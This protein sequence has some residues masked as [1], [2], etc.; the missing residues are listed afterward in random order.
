[1][2][3]QFARKLRRLERTILLALQLISMRVSQRGEGV[4]TLEPHSDNN[5]SRVYDTMGTHGQ[6]RSSYRPQSRCVSIEA[7]V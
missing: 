1:M 4:D 7:A 6:L 2:D 5:D 3:S